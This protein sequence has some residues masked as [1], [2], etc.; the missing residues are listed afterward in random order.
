MLVDGI[1]DV[2]GKEERSER[3]GSVQRRGI[4]S[5]VGGILVPKAIKTVIYIRSNLTSNLTLF[6]MI[7]T[8]GKWVWYETTPS[9]VERRV[10]TCEMLL[11]GQK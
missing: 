3:P 1:Y 7:Q 5:T 11:S 10:W 2:E 8:Q 4:W 6:G 9:N